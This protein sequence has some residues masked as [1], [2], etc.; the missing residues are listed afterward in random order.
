MR[1]KCNTTV[2][3]ILF[4]SV[5]VIAAEN[6]TTKIYK[7]DEIVITATR[8]NR[9]MFD[10]GRNVSVITSK[11]FRVSPL[12]DIGDVLSKE[13]VGF[14]TGATLNPGMQQ[15]LFLRGAN[16][17]QTSVFFDDI[18]LTDPSSTNNA[19]NL[20]ELS[21]ANAEQIEIVRGAHS[22]LYG[23]SAIG[24]V[25]NIIS[26]SNQLPGFHIEADMT[27]GTFG[28][29]TSAL[30]ENIFLNYSLPAGMYVN[31]ALVNSG[32][33]GLD[34]TIDTV[35][36]SSV[37]KNRDR[38][39]FHKLN[40]IGKIGF[41][42][43]DWD[44]HLSFLQ[45]Q[46][47]ADID[48]GAFRDD[49]NARLD[50]ERQLWTIGT[51]YTIND[52]MKLKYIGGYSPIQRHTI[53]DSSV[54]D[55]LGTTDHSF[56][57]DTFKGTTSS[58]EI[59]FEAGM[60]AVRTV[61]GL[62]TQ[63]ETM[64]QQSYLYQGSVFGAYESRTNLDTL[65]LSSTLNHI[66]FHTEIDGT[67][68][69]EELKNLT[70]VLGLRMNH[71][72]SY[73]DNL[74]Y[75]VN[76]S[77]R[78]SKNSLLF[79]SFSTGFNAPSLYQLFCPT[80]YYTSDIT[81]GNVLLHPETS[82]SVELGWKYRL[83][84]R[85]Y[86]MISYF[87]T[88][89]E[90]SIEYVYLWDKNIGLDTLGNNWMRDDYRG[91]TYLNLGKQTTSGLDLIF[92]VH[93]TDFLTIAGS[94]SLI[95]GKLAYYPEDIQNQHIEGNHVQLYSNGAFVTREIE[96]MNLVRRPSSCNVNIQYKPMT[97]LLTQIDIRY[98]GSK[99]DAYYNNAIGPYGAL[100][101][102]KLNDY[103]LIDCAVRYEIHTYLSLNVR[104]E[105]ILDT[106]YS[107]VLG[108]TTKGRALYVGTQLSF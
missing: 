87:H 107:E 99:Y 37:Y 4:F 6:D 79:I 88:L 33:K 90:N 40:V 51:S 106:R 101:V 29:Q 97:A 69:A 5:S 92:D 71:H 27:A 30:T 60:S 49:N 74:T 26:R 16:S 15:S 28:S 55:L 84:D 31:A 36:R 104:V 23:S 95:T 102:L 75:E 72:S 82:S 44:L 58:H 103:T 20:I 48:K 80:T 85:A 9:P 93:L 65:H 13:G 100:D 47:K 83:S 43:E 64:T 25:V 8:V 45:V 7:A 11:E 34:A 18:R 61:I 38:D 52:G 54:V 53:D 22:T 1:Y 10:I 14:I 89:V 39:G 77:Y 56:S 62:G 67:I 76:P 17:N 81:R 3:S 41:R 59:L 2:F 98:V 57:E 105:N 12:N 50:F 86:L 21:L 108:Y 66:L 24:G 32:V 35:T 96:T 19:P 78:V 91:D 42:N 68:L 63:R 94:A 46:E 70:I 73:G